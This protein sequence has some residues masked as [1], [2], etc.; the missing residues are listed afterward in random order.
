MKPKLPFTMPGGDMFYKAGI[1][2][3]AKDVVDFL[4]CCWQDDEAGAPIMWSM[5]QLNF[6][7]D[8]WDAYSSFSWKDGPAPTP[9]PLYSALTT[10]TLNIRPEPS[11]QKPAIGLLAKGAKMNVWFVEKGWAAIDQSKTRWCSTDY[12]KKV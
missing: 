9:D 10:N 5:D 12:L 1:K 6:V 11:T 7:P 4:T 2:P 8:L 3:T